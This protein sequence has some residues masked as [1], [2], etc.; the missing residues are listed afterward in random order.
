M[1]QDKDTYCQKPGRFEPPIYHYDGAYILNNNNK[2]NSLNQFTKNNIAIH[3]Y[4][5]LPLLCIL[6]RLVKSHCFFYNNR[7]NFMMVR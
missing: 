3:R 1:F 5:T 7:K 4:F 2:K 6:K